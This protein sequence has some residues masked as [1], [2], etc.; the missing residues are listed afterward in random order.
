MDSILA[1]IQARMGSTRLPG[2]V[3][4]DIMGRP[5]LG[6][7]YDRLS[8]C[9]QIRQTVVATSTQPSDMAIVNFCQAEDIPVFQGSEQDVLDRFF[10]VACRFKPQHV[11]RVTADCPLLDP[12]LI[13]KLI[14]KYLNE[15]LDYCAI[16]TGAGA[17]LDQGKGTF[18]DGLDCEIFRYLALEEAWTH[19]TTPMQR[20]H[21]TPYI[22]QQDKK[23]KTGKLFCPFEYGS[24]RLTVDYPEDFKLVDAVYRALSPQNKHYSYLAVIEYLQKNRDLESLNRQHIG[25]EGYEAFYDQ[26][27]PNPL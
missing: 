25:N 27:S 14:T 9:P 17:Y 11:I 24:Y 19:A 8:S 22:W 23:F 20:E 4:K 3:L 15:D 2:K 7:I 26:A 21:V 12:G 18:P 13:S 6:H 5:I 1:I 16:A 10:Q